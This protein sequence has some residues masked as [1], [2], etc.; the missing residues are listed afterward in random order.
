MAFHGGERARSGLEGSLS[1]VVAQTNVSLKS[2]GF[3]LCFV[4]NE[5]MFQT[6]QEFLQDTWFPQTLGAFC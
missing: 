4:H 3:L 1:Q 2:T 6:P 5:T